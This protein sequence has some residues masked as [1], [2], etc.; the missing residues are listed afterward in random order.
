L[1]ESKKVII[2]A[3]DPFIELDLFL[4]FQDRK[5]VIVVG[6]SDGINVYPSSLYQIEPKYIIPH[7]INPDKYPKYTGEMGTIA[8]CNRKPIE[9]W[10]DLSNGIFKRIISLDE[11]LGDVPYRILQIP[12]DKDFFSELAKYRAV[13]YY[14]NNPYTLMMFELMTMGMPMIAFGHSR[15]GD[16]VMRK[17]IQNVSTD[18]DEIKKFLSDKLSQ[19]PKAE[20]YSIY[21]FAK[22]KAEWNKIICEL[23]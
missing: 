13:F 2:Y 8:I 20:K 9:R 1:P 21:P 19:A 3:T 10:N 17:Y 5:N 23:T 12:D 18:K 4:R 6:D 7:A 14:S 15:Y 16:T 11:F 22:A